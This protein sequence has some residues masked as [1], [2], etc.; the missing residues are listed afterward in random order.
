MAFASIKAKFLK[1][2][3]INEVQYE[4]VDD[5]AYKKYQIINQDSIVYLNYKT[6]EL[7][8]K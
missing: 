4:C 2:V 6:I 1:Y 5:N 8:N 7:Y 3:K